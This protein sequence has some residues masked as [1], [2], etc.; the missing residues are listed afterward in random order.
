MTMAEPATMWPKSFRW[1]AR[2][3]P[4]SE[5]N[6]PSTAMTN[7]PGMSFSWK[8]AR[9]LFIHAPQGNF[10]LWSVR[11]QLLVLLELHRCDNLIF[12]GASRNLILDR[13]PCINQYLPHAVQRRSSCPGV[14]GNG[15]MAR[16]EDIGA[17]RFY[18]IQHSQP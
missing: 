18:R 6:L 3:I 9:Q 16:H 5:F 2:S 8:V 12:G 14:F 1:T 13:V 10:P 17:E 15:T 11:R 4:M 7:R